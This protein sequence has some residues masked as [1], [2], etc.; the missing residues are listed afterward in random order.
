M[1]YMEFLGNLE[2]PEDRA[3][4]VDPATRRGRRFDDEVVDAV[5]RDTLGYPYFIQFYGDAL[6]KGSAGDVVR[7]E[8]FHRLRPAI[9]KALDGSFF[10]ARFV[11]ASA[12][13]QNLLR[14]I[15]RHGESANLR[16]LQREVGRSNSQLQPLLASLTAKGLVYRPSRGVFAFTAPM[17]GAYVT[18]RHATA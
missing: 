5:M 17:F 8:D 6:W 2:P 1:F 11:R 10:D 14:A 16:V 18:R 3:A 7:F 13:E 15:A 4:L 12:Q 9:L